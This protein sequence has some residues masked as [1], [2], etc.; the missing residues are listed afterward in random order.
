M[1]TG[2]YLL[3]LSLVLALCSGCTTTRTLSVSPANRTAATSEQGVPC[4]QSAKKNVVTVWLLTPQYQTDLRQFDLP[5]FR[6]L[7]RNGGDQAF[8][9]S[10]ANVT[11]SSGGNSVH[12][13]TSGEYCEAI[14]RRAEVLLQYVDR[15]TAQQKAQEEQTR[16]FLATAE[17][18][19]YRD[20]NKTLGRDLALLQSGSAIEGL[21]GIEGAAADQRN[22]INL[23]RKNLLDEA[24][25]MLVQQTVEPGLMAGGIIKLDLVQISRGQPLKLVV[26]VG[27]EAHE[28]VF[29]VG[30]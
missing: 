23:K 4:L 5:A 22:A 26:T 10:P 6:V 28:F 15:Q 14:D 9:F 24:Q 20:W 13:F 25:L 18:P 27:G 7:V 19:E 12:V 1:K 30:G 3:G 8:D 2:R 21:P 29:E 11:A 17:P 16:V